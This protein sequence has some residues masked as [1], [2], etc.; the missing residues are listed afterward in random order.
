[1]FARGRG[2]VPTTRGARMVGD[3]AGVAVVVEAGERKGR[4]N[5]IGR[6]AFAGGAVFGRHA[7]AFVGGKSG[8][9]KAVEDVDGG[10]VDWAVG[11]QVLDDMVPE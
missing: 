1:M 7:L 6:E 11:E 10:L 4:V 3:D 9:V 8:M 2:Q 5:Q